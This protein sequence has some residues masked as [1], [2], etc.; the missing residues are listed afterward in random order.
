[1]A[2]L[3]IALGPLLGL[4]ALALFA[5]LVPLHVLAISALALVGVGFVLSIPAGLYYH[6]L[7][8]RELLARGELPRGW[9]WRPQQYHGDLEPEAQ[10]RLAPW[11]AVGVVVFVLTMVGFVLAVTALLLWLRS[12]RAMLP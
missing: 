6:L 9:Y 10:R 12:E 5:L 7:L 3:L 1:V 2:E 4:V 8:R 11:F